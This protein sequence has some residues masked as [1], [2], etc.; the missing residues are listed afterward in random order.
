MRLPDQ[1]A[2]LAERQLGV[3]ARR[4]FPA[5]IPRSTVDNLVRRG[6]LVRLARGVYA[7]RGGAV[8]P[9]REAVAAALRAGPR[10]TVTG[11]AALALAPVEGLVLGSRFAL[12]VPPP[13][14]ITRDHVVLRP[15]RDPGRQVRRL[16]QVR[17]AAAVDALLDSIVLFGR[18]LDPRAL[19]LVH[20]QL[21]WAGVLTAGD[22]GRRARELKVA[23]VFAAH[24]LSELDATAATGDGERRLGTLLASFD[25]AP[26]PQVWVTPDRCVDW[27]FRSVRMGVEYQGSV[28]HEGS[29]GRARDRA[30]ERELR[31]TGIHLIYVSAA[32]LRDSS[33]LIASVAGALAARAHELRVTAPQ[34]RGQ[35]AG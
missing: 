10:A 19:K 14:R 2:D 23:T 6:P 18:A 34:L 33:S 20:D 24:E 13:I 22:L 28:D 15:D 26:Q 16:G 7:V 11:P 32:D 17:V 30:R 35:P 8:H 9:Q 27:Y 31:R 25:P 29:A 21:R 3:L 5:E 1:M 12:L 4:Q